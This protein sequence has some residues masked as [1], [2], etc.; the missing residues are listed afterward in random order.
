[1]QKNFSKKYIKNFL[2]ELIQNFFFQKKLYLHKN[3]LFK[4]ILLQNQN[5]LNFIEEKTND[6]IKKILL[7]FFPQIL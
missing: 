4:N 6:D 3:F 5:L 2:R 7:V 1:M